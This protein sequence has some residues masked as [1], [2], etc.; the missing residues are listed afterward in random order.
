[1]IAAQITAHSVGN[2]FRMSFLLGQPR[3]IECYNK[4]QNNARGAIDFFLH[5]GK[6]L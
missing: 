2:K 1:M 4:L 6:K 5:I 3:Y